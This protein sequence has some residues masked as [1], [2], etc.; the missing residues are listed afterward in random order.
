MIA[1]LCRLFSEPNNQIPRPEVNLDR[2]NRM[3]TE[4]IR[5]KAEL[6]KQFAQLKAI[7]GKPI[8]RLIE[9]ACEAYA[10][11]MTRAKK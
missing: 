10:A 6:R 1:I 7:T 11:K 9:E 4:S 5:I 2:K 8:K 3:K